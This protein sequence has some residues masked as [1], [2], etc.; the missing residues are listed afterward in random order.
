MHHIQ[1][2]GRFAGILLGGLALKRNWQ[3]RMK[4]AGKS[5]HEP[6]P[7]VSLCDPN[8]KLKHLSN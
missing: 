8:P 1:T 5:I 3:T 7:N 2:Y 4:A 6:G